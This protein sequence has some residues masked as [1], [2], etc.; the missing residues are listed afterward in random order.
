M[1]SRE[2]EPE[3]SERVEPRKP[4]LKPCPSCG[5][6]DVGLNYDL[7]LVRRHGKKVWVKTWYGYCNGGPLGW[8]GPKRRTKREAIAAWN[9]LKRPLEKK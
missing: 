4:K 5:G 7:D 1:E 8:G 3:V 6:T 9:R 2:G